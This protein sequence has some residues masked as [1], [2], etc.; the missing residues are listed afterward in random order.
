MAFAQVIFILRGID[1][2]QVFPVQNLINQECGWGIFLQGQKTPVDSH[3]IPIPK[4]LA[5]E[6]FLLHLC[7]HV[8]DLTDAETGDDRSWKKGKDVVAVWIKPPSA[9]FRRTLRGFRYS[10]LLTEVHST[11]S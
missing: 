7:M 4:P 10:G 9:I 1:D 8:R 2:N 6:I 5:F 11:P 3:A